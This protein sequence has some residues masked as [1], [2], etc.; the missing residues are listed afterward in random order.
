MLTQY[1]E[2]RQ[3]PL[4]PRVR[5]LPAFDYPRVRLQPGELE[6]PTT[7][8]S[9]KGTSISTMPRQIFKHST[10]RAASLL[11]RIRLPEQPIFESG[12]LIELGHAM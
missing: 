11:P 3:F 6:S 5:L 7:Q 4:L 1:E 12:Q 2:F 8:R 10:P 9:G